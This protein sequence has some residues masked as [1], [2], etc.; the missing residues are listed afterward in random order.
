MAPKKLLFKTLA[1]KQFSIEI[2]DSITIAQVKDKVSQ[3]QG[4][5]PSN[6]KL[7]YSGPSLSILAI[8]LSFVSLNPPS[9]AWLLAIG[10]C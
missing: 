10:N 1:Q 4:F 2:D 6:Q 9:L 8:S 3:S 7:I 5:A